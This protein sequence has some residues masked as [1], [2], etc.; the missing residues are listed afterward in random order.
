VGFV[1]NVFRV[2]NHVRSKYGKYR[3][4]DKDDKSGE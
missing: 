2:R 1:R 3:D 4:E